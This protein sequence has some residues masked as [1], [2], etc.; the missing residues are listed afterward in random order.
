MSFDSGFALWRAAMAWQRALDAA[1][2]P[3]GL[4]HTQYLVLSAAQECTA[5]ARDAVAQRTIARKA[6]LD[7]ATMSRIARTL[8]E[9]KLFDRGGSAD[10]R[11]WRI[12]LTEEGKRKLRAAAPIARATEERFFEELRRAR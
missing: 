7:E 11:A 10:G 1:L 3:L 12:L 6:G 2:G 9:R 5:E 4:T 8:D